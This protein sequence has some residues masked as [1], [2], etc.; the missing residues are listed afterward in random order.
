MSGRWIYIFDAWCGWSHAFRPTVEALRSRRPEL[1]WMVIPGG[2]LVGPRVGKC[3]PVEVQHRANARVRAETGVLFGKGYLKALEAGELALNSETAGRAFEALRHVAPHLA[4]TW[5]FAQ[6]EAVWEHGLDP[7]EPK[8]LKGMAEAHGVDGEAV[9]AHYASEAAEAEAQR[10]FTQVKGFQVE[11]F[12]TL[13]WARNNQGLH[14]AMGAAS[15]DK[16][17]ERLATHGDL[18]GLT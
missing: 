4:L 7:A 13:M 9:L 12:P 3:M 18:V 1:P 15:A 5:A 6:T 14:V 17:W 11:G 8:V 10:R 16:V 2:L